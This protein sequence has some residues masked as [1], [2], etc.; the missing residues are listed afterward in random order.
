MAKEKA[1]YFTFLLYP[2]SIPID[3]ELKLETLG[4]PIAVSPLHD[5]DKSNVEGQKYKK[6]HY[7]VIYIAKNPVT[8]DSVRWK[9]K[10]ILGEQSVAMV[11]VALNVE[12]TYLYL[13][14]ESK[15]AIA[16]KKHVYD[17]VDIKLIN[18]FDIDRYVTLDVEKKAELFNVVVSLIRAYTL[19]NIFDLYDF[20]DENGETYGL[21]INLVN[22]V[23]SG[24][25]GFMKLL[26]D[27]AYQRSKRGIKSRAEE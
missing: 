27:G 1:R 19:Q 25:T 8:A 10:K 6:P 24:K 13:T 23:I 14:H 2:E 15:D 12:N 26:F 18:N 3:W 7:H 11:Q 5:K 9:I 22:E 21:T 17:K 4:V 20:I 16:K